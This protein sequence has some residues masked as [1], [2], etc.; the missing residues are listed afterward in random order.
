MTVR[1][2]EMSTTRINGRTEIRNR[3]YM[4]NSREQCRDNTD[5]GV[6]DMVVMLGDVVRCGMVVGRPA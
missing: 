1:I 6:Y 3:S 4:V 5:R 2:T